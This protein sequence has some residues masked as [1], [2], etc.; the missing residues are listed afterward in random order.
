MCVAREQGNND[1]NHKII[2]SSYLLHPE[3][4]KNALRF[5]V[6]MI[7]YSLSAINEYFNDYRQDSLFVCV[8]K[9]CSQQIKET[10]N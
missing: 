4:E 9:V 10:V 1:K 6:C 2:L 7:S 3:E 5:D 8:P